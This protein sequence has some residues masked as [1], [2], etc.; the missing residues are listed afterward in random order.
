M[1]TFKILGIVVICSLLL[2]SS[3]RTFAHG[4]ITIDGNCTTDWGTALPGS[5]HG[6]QVVYGG[7][8]TEWVYRGEAGDARDDGLSTSSNNDIIEVRFTGDETNLYFCI[9]M[10]GITSLEIPNINLAIDIDQSD[11]DT[12]LTLVGDETCSSP[13]ACGGAD[14]YII[15]DRINYADRQYNAHY[16]NNQPFDTEAAENMPIMFDFAPDGWFPIDGN[17]AAARIDTDSVEGKINWSILGCSAGPCEN[18]YVNLTSYRNEPGLAETID[19]TYDLP[20]SD[21]IDV[22]GGTPGVTQNAWERDFSDG[23]LSN[24]YHVQFDLPSAVHLQSATIR[25]TP[26]I[27]IS[28]VGMIILALSGLI[29]MIRFQEKHIQ[30]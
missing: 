19:T 28:Y 20:E 13:T 5:V 10:A 2:I 11:E 24:F 26:D 14:R 15:A 30:K 4:G 25:V 18:I 29:W 9:K 6:T 21:G 16:N 8:G 23:Q 3:Q 12:Q 7:G 1:K 27:K 17:T 22:M